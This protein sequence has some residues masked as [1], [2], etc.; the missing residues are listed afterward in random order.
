MKK[1]LS[2]KV[3]ILL[4]LTTIN[5]V[6]AQGTSP[7][8]NTISITSDNAL[9]QMAL[10]F[11]QWINFSW[12]SSNPKSSAY[13]V[14]AECPVNRECPVISCSANLDDTFFSEVHC[15]TSK[16]IEMV[17]APCTID[18][19]T[20]SN[21]QPEK[22]CVAKAFNSSGP[23]TGFIS[24]I[25]PLHYDRRYRF[26]VNTHT[27]AA[28]NQ[29]VLNLIGSTV[30]EAVEISMDSLPRKDEEAQAEKAIDPSGI[31][32][33][34]N[35]GLSR[36]ITS[37]GLLLSRTNVGSCQNELS[38]REFQ[39]IYSESL[40]KKFVNFEDSI[41][42]LRSSSKVFCDKA[43]RQVCKDL[44]KKSVFS[45]SRNSK[46]LINDYEKLLSGLIISEEDSN[47][48]ATKADMMSNIATYDVAASE[49]NKAL[50][51]YVDKITVFTADS[52]LVLA[53]TESNFD[54]H[55]RWH[56]SADA[57]FAYIP[58]LKDV[59]GYLGTNIYFRPI[60]RDVPLSVLEQ[61]STSTFLN[62]F[63]VTIGITVSSVEKS[64]QR[65]GLFG[66]Q[67]L[68]LGA[69][70]RVTDTIRLNGGAL[71]YRERSVNPL[72]GDLSIAASPF[73]GVS[74]DVNVAKAFNG[75]S[76]ILGIP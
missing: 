48:L 58:S 18:T 28:V 38:A 19:F 21:I 17:I 26:F 12:S 11:D 25:P 60:N 49:L 57:G 43:F 37:E 75:F 31:C 51:N 61:R 20:A 50:E 59:V 66:S 3:S 72:N 30:S 36:K 10:P 46:N 56:I 7:P 45:Q 24:E 54:T 52:F 69:G 16:L 23:K 8:S 53:S 44:F 35:A 73:V 74:F 22:F 4:F 1:E 42:N 2:L 47:G 65:T 64:N 6:I 39:E 55:Q 9:T 33:K 41:I 29:N 40:L 32:R 63:S 62:R 76:K 67:G 71:V 68:I 34:I 13:I 70:Y 14:V 27:P 15:K 5:P